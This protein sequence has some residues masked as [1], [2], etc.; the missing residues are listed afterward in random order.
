[1]ATHLGLVSGEVGIRERLEAADASFSGGHFVYTGGDHGTG[2]AKLDPARTDDDLLA[3]VCE[4]LMEPFA[5]EFD[6]VVGGAKGGIVLATTAAE[7]SKTT[8]NPVE[9][10]WAEKAPDGGFEIVDQAI[11]DAIRGKKVL[12]LEDSVNRKNGGSAYRLGREVLRCG[13]V[14]VGVSS[15]WN[16]GKATAADLGVP[17]FESLIRLDTETFPAEQCRLCD[18]CVPVVED[19][20]HASRFRAANPNYPGGFRTVLNQ[21]SLPLP[22]FYVTRS[23]RLAVDP[24]VQAQLT[25][26]IA[27]QQL[28]FIKK[29][30][31]AA[32]QNL[33]KESWDGM[34]ELTNNTADRGTTPRSHLYQIV[35]A[36]S[37]IAEVGR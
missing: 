21:D 37:R 13:G 10:Y 4:K 34:H 17:R 32:D 25:P 26:E 18:E 11:R 5:G 12:E 30:F 27:Q 20:G 9:G 36:Y 19:L 3:D 2:Y 15:I 16:Y 29:K 7:V 22:L 23:G 35:T 14:L 24:E 8:Q 31:I 1:M 33:D 6:V 28:T